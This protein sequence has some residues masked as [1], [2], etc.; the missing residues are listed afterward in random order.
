MASQQYIVT[1]TDASRESF[2]SL[3]SA[4]SEAEAFE[5][6]E[7]MIRF[8]EESGQLWRLVGWRSEIYIQS[9]Y[10]GH[11]FVPNK[12]R[13]SVVGNWNPMPWAMSNGELEALA[14]RF[15]RAVSS[16]AEI[17]VERQSIHGV[18]RL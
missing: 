3:V 6:T 4:F 8:G 1:T 16:G 10:D 18:S 17:H 7:E 12:F 2:R 14:A 13:A 11:R 9:E 15:E 5:M